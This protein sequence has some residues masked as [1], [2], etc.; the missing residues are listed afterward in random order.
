MGEMRINLDR[1]AAVHAVRGVVNL[2]Q[3]VRRPADVIGGQQ[4]YCL[5]DAQ[6]ESREPGEVLVIDV[7]A[8]DGLLEDGRVARHPDDRLVAYQPGKASTHQAIPRQVVQPDRHALFGQLPQRVTHRLIPSPVIQFNMAGPSRTPTRCDDT[9]H[10]TMARSP[11]PR[12]AS[13]GCRDFCE[14]HAT[15]FGKARLDTRGAVSYRWLNLLSRRYWRG[16]R[17]RLPSPGPA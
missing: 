4:A 7:A 16:W 12:S 13:G 10:S 14:A 17:G 15:P 3:H 9:P 11:G 2:P 8:G 5:G 6:A 1:Y